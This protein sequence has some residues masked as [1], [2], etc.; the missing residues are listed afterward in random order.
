ML[1]DA[2]GI[3]DEGTKKKTEIALTD[4]NADE[5]MNL[6]NKINSQ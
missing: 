6:I 2:P 3:E 1:I 4:E 5:I